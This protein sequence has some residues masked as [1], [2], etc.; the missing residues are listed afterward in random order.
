MAREYEYE[1][2]EDGNCSHEAVDESED[3]IGSIIPDSSRLG[4]NDAGETQIERFIGE[5]DGEMY[6]DVITKDE[7]GKPI[8]VTRR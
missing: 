5:E 6:E 3:R 4:I 7:N 2:D 8:H 1:Y